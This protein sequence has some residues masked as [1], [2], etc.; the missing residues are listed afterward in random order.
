MKF[1]I[2]TANLDEISEANDLGILDGVTTNPSLMAKEGITGE[3]NTIGGLQYIGKRLLDI[4]GSLIGLGLTTLL[5]PFIAIGIK[6]TSKGNVFFRQER[7]GANGK[8]FN[9]IKFRTMREG[10]EDEL[11]SLVDFEKLAE[12]PAYK[13]DNDPRVTN[14]GRFLRRWSLDELPQFWNVLRGD[15]SLIGPRPFLPEQQKLYKGSAYY[16][17]RPGLTGFWQVGDRNESSFAAR[18]VF[19]NRYAQELTLLTDLRILMRTIGVVLRGTG[20]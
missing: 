12:S 8:P 9:I 3:E 14:I 10:A 2:D 19:D 20:V 18:T 7:I 1:F 17:L 16:E 13:I 15:M 4:V 6:A 11:E 5:F